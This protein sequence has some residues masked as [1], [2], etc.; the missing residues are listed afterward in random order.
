MYPNRA[1]VFILAAI[2]G[3][4]RPNRGE[5]TNTSIA[6]VQVHAG[7]TRR[8]QFRQQPG[9]GLRSWAV[10]C[11]GQDG[12]SGARWGQLAE[13]GHRGFYFGRT[14]SAGCVS[15][16]SPR[17]RALGCVDLCLCVSP[18]FVPL[19][20][21]LSV[22]TQQTFAELYGIDQ[23]ASKGKSKASLGFQISNK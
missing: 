11:P 16:V 3:N 4:P 5:H 12:G 14:D 10:Y 22:G 17:A 6:G 8:P 15:F 9:E 7:G 21:M 23:V 19:I 13:G 20:L 18:S 1:G 2:Q